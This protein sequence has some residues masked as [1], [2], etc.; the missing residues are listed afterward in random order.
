MK[1]LH[2]GLVPRVAGWREAG[3]WPLRLRGPD[4]TV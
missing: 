4:R 2:Q 3:L 1:L